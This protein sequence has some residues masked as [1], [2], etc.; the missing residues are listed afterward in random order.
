M[1]KQVDPEF[2]LTEQ[3]SL[4]SKALASVTEPWGRLAPSTQLGVTVVSLITV[5]VTVWFLARVNV[6]TEQQAI[7]VETVKNDPGVDPARREAYALARSRCDQAWILASGAQTALKSLHESIKQRAQF[8]E[9]LT[10]NDGRLLASNPQAVEAVDAILRDPGVTAEEADAYGQ[11][12]QPLADTLEEARKSPDSLFSP[13]E[14]MFNELNRLKTVLREADQALREKNESMEI[15]LTT[16]RRQNQP[17]PMTLADAIERLRETQALQR[18]DYLAGRE[19]ARRRE[20]D[21]TLA[22]A[23]DDRHRRLTEAKNQARDSE[24]AQ[25]ELQI[26]ASRADVKKKYG[27]FLELGKFKPVRGKNPERTE[28]ALPMSYTDLKA[29]GV[30]DDYKTFAA[31]GAGKW[32]HKIRKEVDRPTWPLP[33]KDPDFDPYKELFRDFCD[34]APIWAKDGTLAP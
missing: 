9:L 32:E 6:T 4:V 28:T 12:L 33:T 17:A 20:A 10:S 13:S 27:P 22:D 30:F 14:D 31:A 1:S 11:S 24:T 21:K 25:E 8:Q 23:E 34:L 26:K 7:A 16:A 2:K 3:E 29:F 18:A 19:E 5:G 15:L